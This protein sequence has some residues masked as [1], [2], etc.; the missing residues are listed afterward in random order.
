MDYVKTRL[1]LMGEG[2]KSAHAASPIRVAKDIIKTQGAAAL[3][4]GISAAYAR[5]V[6]YGSA[7]LG[8]FRTFSNMFKESNAGG[9]LQGFA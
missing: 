8:L 5:Q 4:T 7:R 2:Q 3:Y 9:T 6:V 1:Q